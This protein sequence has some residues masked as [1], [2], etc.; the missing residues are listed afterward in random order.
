MSSVRVTVVLLLVVP[1]KKVNF[2]KVLTVLA[3][4][5]MHMRKE[6]KIDGP[7]DILHLNFT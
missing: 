7:S 4:N 3:K 1:I 2:K 5:I 6:C